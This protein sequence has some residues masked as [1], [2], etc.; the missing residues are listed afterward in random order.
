[1]WAKREKK[2]TTLTL[3]YV[4]CLWG[5]IQSSFS[6]NSFSFHPKKTFLL[7]C[8]LFKTY[9]FAFILLLVCYYFYFSFS[10]SH[11]TFL[12]FCSSLA[13][14]D[15]TQ[16]FFQKIVKEHI[17]EIFRNCI[18]FAPLS[19]SSY[20]YFAAFML[21]RGEI[22]SCRQNFFDLDSFFSLP[23]V[24]LHSSSFI[25]HD[26]NFCLIN[27]LNV[28]VHK[29]FYFGNNLYFLNIYLTDRK[30]LSKEK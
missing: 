10:T 27:E 1:M 12:C 14:H 28:F 26:I 5:N 8:K 9:S 21:K 19:L 18:F 25:L 17:S 16:T 3:V 29:F 6:W 7:F 20:I 24:F 13:F 30:F 23:F 11:R 4:R 15:L 22:Y 2:Y